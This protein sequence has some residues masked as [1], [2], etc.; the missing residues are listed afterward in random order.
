MKG[1]L[2]PA[3]GSCARPSTAAFGRRSGFLRKS[4][5]F[6]HLAPQAGMVCSGEAATG[7]IQPVELRRPLLTGQ[8]EGCAV[9][10]TQSGALAPSSRHRLSQRLFPKNVEPEPAWPG[11]ISQQLIISFSWESWSKAGGEG[12]GRLR[13]N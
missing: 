12:G 1:G 4:S 6:S 2:F 13:R 10:S 9:L 5:L 8:G 11:G 3:V 7:Q